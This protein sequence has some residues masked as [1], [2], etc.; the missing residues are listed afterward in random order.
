MRGSCEGTGLCLLL[1]CGVACA[2]QPSWKELVQSADHLSSQGNFREAETALLNA[3]KAAEAFVQPDLRLAETQHHLG[4]VYK[5][6][7][8]LLEA[9]RWYRQSLTTW[10]ATAGER[11]PSLAKPLI[12]LTSL[13]LEN[14]L[15][16]R[17]EQVLGR[18]LRDPIQTIDPAL[19]VRLLHNFA[20][21]QHA[22][23]RYSEAE[24]LYAQALKAAETVFGPQSQEVALLLNNLGMLLADSGKSQ[25]AG[26]HL[27]RALAI[28]ESALPSNHP[29]VARAL[30]NLAA[31]YCSTGK[32]STAEPLFHRALSSAENGLGPENPLLAKILA[33]Y[34]VLLR[35]TKRKKEAK[36]FETRART[37]RKEHTLEDLA[38]HTIDLSD[39]LA[40]KDTRIG[41]NR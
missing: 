3:L 12:S 31:F 21:L 24:T 5:E 37:I 6:L 33:E 15:H 27:E 25:E 34:A 2:G 10:K 39:L 9:E 7:G 40:S 4:T 16:G 19:S 26:A 29:D 32:Y 11:D 1:V 23:R 13:Y 35:K 17:A 28:W 41:G 18:W 20:A 36:L 8:R 30:T 22:Q 38:R 14:G